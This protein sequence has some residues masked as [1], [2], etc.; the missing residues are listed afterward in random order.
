MRLL[1]GHPDGALETGDVSKRE[2]GCRIAITGRDG[3][4]Q[5]RMLADMFSKG[6]RLVDDQA[7]DPRG[8][9]VVANEDVLEMRVAGGSVDQLM[10]GHVFVDEGGSIAG[11]HLEALDLG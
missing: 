11:D 3:F 7:P 2:R 9:V 10:D 5:E 1:R 8:E 6:G 4:E